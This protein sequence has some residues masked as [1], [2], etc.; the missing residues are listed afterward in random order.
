MA[1]SHTFWHVPLNFLS[2]KD[3]DIK[4]STVLNTFLEEIGALT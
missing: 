2:Q 3:A 4:G 1:L